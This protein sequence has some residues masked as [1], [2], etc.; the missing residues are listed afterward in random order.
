MDERARKEYKQ[1]KTTSIN[2]VILDIY[3]YARG[4]K[5]RFDNGE[6]LF[7]PLTSA[8]NENNIFIF[9]AQKGDRVLKKPSQDTLTLIKKDGTMLKY[10]F[11]K[12][13]QE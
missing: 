6:I 7:Y 5:L 3:P 2:H 4:V 9:T 11:S 13:K 12:P 8:L 1:F 10:T